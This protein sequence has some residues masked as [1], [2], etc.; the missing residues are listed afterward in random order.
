MGEHLAN[1]SF[2]DASVGELQRVAA[3]D[4]TAVSYNIDKNYRTYDYKQ[5]YHS[6]INN[7]F[8][9]YGEYSRF[10]DETFEIF[11]NSNLERNF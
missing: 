11:C 7:L 3:E 8:K 10:F 6:S 5:S 4:L 2:Y 9:T 1:F